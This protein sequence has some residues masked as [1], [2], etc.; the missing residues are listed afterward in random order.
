[1]PGNGRPTYRWLRPAVALLCATAIVWP[2][3]G[4]LA[5]VRLPSM[6]DTA[7][8]DIPLGVERRYGDQVM[9]E[10]WRDPSI[11]DDPVLQEYLQ[12]LWTRLLQAARARGDID[13]DVWSQFAWRVFLV[14]DRSVNAFALPGGWVGVHLGLIAMTATEHE[15]AAVLAHELSHVSQRHI[16]RGIAS[17]GRQ[18]TVGMVAM[19]LGML[20][21]SRSGNAD[22]AQAAIVGSQAALIQGQLNFS[23]DMEREADRIGYGVFHQAGFD[24]A[25]MAG[26]F[27]KLGQASRPNDSGA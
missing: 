21:A 6:G 13:D 22:V 14:R 12:S 20:A 25:G 8:D 16:A 5:Q 11:L 15:L 23:R 26:M 24:T 19:L 10:V 7:S 9:R 2:A 3:G 27:D 18:S 1:M 4:P 17:S